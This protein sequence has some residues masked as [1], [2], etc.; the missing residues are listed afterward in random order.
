MT[1]DIYLQNAVTALQSAEDYNCNGE[2]SKAQIQIELADRWMALAREFS[3]L[4]SI[5]G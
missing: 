3:L 4:A 2:R 5:N 1:P